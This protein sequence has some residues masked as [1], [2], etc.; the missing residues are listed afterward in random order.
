M[1]ALRAYAMRL[2]LTVAQ[3]MTAA[4]S[5]SAAPTAVVTMRFV[6]CCDKREISV[7]VLRSRGALKA[8]K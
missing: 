6:N 3:S 8:V 5:V 4:I 2:N 1:L 7:V